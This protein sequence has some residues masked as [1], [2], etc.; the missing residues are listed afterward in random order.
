MIGFFDAL[1]KRYEGRMMGGEEDYADK[2]IKQ[3]VEKEKEIVVKALE[4]MKG[5]EFGAE[6]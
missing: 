2:C 5:G 4:F 1:L 3:I 6:L